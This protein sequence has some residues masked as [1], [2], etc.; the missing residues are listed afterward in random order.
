VPSTPGEEIVLPGESLAKYRAKPAVAPA[1][2]PIV[3]HE[4]R[5]EKHNL[6]EI[7]PRASGNLPSTAASGSSVPRRFSGGLPRW[8]LADA[9]AEAEATPSGETA[10]AAGETSVPDSALV[11]PSQ[12][13]AATNVEAARMTLN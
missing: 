7:T 1:S 11:E 5:E 3:E 9:G 8:L 13:T 4:T 10:G 2:V 12:E 6:E